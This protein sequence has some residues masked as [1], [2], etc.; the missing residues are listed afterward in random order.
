M[1]RLAL[2]GTFH[3]NLLLVRQRPMPRSGQESYVPPLP[4]RIQLSIN[5]RN[6]EIRDGHTTCRAEPVRLAS[7]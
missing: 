3:G 7:R 2:I 4:T 6:I 1:G 5:L